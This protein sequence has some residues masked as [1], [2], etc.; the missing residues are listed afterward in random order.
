MRAVQMLPGYTHKVQNL[1]SVQDLVMVIWANEP[2]DPSYPD[3][4]FQDVNEERH[5][6]DG[7]NSC[8]F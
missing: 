2:Y 3:T 8:E 5:G 6:E 4:Y 7:L 1:S